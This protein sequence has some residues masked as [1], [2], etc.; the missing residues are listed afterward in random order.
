MIEAALDELAESIR[1]HGMLQ[2]IVVMKREGTFEILA[3]ERRYRAAK[4]L[5]LNQVPVVIRDAL[6]EESM[7]E[8]RLIENIQ[9]ENL[10]PIELAL[11]Y[12][13]LIE[14]HGLQQ[15]QVAERLGKPRSSIANTLRLL[16]L[17]SP[18]QAHLRHGKLS[19][20]HAKALASINDE[21][22]CIELAEQC[23]EQGWSV[24]A[25]EQQVKGQTQSERKP[26]P[27]RGHKSPHIKELEENLSKLF[28]TQVAVNEKSGK[29][30][31]T[32]QFHSKA[33][34]RQLID[35]L[36]RASQQAKMID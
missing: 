14:A 18:I 20:G 12:Q 30:S 23:L 27:G 4:K 25:L 3:G 15:E 35:Q 22:Q 6:D 10:N 19:M 2:P 24:R 9:R 34:F 1:I 17:P 31:L 16:R 21:A 13:D 28:G 32:L 8:L 33:H 11:A 29:G 7:A 26:G 5:G 36:E